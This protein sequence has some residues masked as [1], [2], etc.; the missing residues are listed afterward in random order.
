MKILFQLLLFIQCSLILNAQEFEKVNTQ[1]VKIYPVLQGGGYILGIDETFVTITD[2]EYNELH[3][4]YR[5]SGF[6]PDAYYDNDFTDSFTINVYDSL[7][8]SYLTK[9]AF[10]WQKPITS[11]SHYIVNRYGLFTIYMKEKE[12]AKINAP[13]AS[14]PTRL[15]ITPNIIN[16]QIRKEFIIKSDSSGR[17]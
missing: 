12:I 9:D 10:G 7:N 3:N 13:S 16:R 14:Y 8:A 17:E 1:W 4:I 11:I 6:L 2:L 15:L 5:I